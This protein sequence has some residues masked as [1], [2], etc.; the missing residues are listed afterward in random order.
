MEEIIHRDVREIVHDAVKFELDNLNG[1]VTALEN[2]IKEIYFIL[3]RM[4]KQIS[5]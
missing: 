5:P 1:R 2:D 3:A 4:E